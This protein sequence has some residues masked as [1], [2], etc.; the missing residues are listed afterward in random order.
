[1]SEVEFEED[2]GGNKTN[3]NPVNSGSNSYGNNYNRYNN[4]T[5]ERGMTGWLIRHHIV[6]SAT[7][8]QYILFAIMIINLVIM[9]IA[10]GYVI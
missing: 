6:K 7:G 5:E 9:F 1:M 4:Q 3:V 8:A 10:F 2:F